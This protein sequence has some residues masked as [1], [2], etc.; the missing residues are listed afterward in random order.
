MKN[1]PYILLKVF[2]H[3]PMYMAHEEVNMML[4]LLYQ[5]PFLSAHLTL[6]MSYHNDFSRYSYRLQDLQ[7]APYP[8]ENQI[9]KQVHTSAF[10]Q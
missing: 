3:F 10:P 5:C 9:L 1:K 8:L 7:K 6:S 4:I 2:L